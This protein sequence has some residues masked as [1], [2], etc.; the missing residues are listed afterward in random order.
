MG[1]SGRCAQFSCR[2][3]SFNI[4]IL[5]IGKNLSSPLEWLCTDAYGSRSRSRWSRQTVSGV[6]GLTQGRISGKL[7]NVPFKTLIWRYSQPGGEVVSVQAS[8]YTA[9][10]WVCS[11]ELVAFS[12][13][14][15]GS[16]FVVFRDLLFLSQRVLDDFCNRRVEFQPFSF[17]IVDFYCLVRLGPAVIIWVSLA[18]SCRT[19]KSPFFTWLAGMVL[20]YWST[21]SGETSAKSTKV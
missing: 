15:L 20:Q 8:S 2:H 17:E 18:S 4:P 6:W 14:V 19:A 12:R 13:R 5:L 11:A 9:D 3:M 21:I 10:F 1:C 16:C 7:A